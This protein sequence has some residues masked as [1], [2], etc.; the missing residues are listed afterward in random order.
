M[1][2]FFFLIL[3]LINLAGAAAFSFVL[4]KALKQRELLPKLL[5]PLLVI[6]YA[7]LS[8]LYLVFAF[9]KYPNSF[10]VTWGKW[11]EWAGLFCLPQALL[12][13][14]YLLLSRVLSFEKNTH[15]R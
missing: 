11:Y 4:V 14:T 2:W 6:P 8:L 12:L 13:I 7:M 10:L 5:S 9:S 3:A 1:E 15:E